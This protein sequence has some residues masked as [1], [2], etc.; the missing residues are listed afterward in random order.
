MNPTS[1]AYPMTDP[2]GPEDQQDGGD[3]SRSRR[4][5]T[6][7]TEGERELSQDAQ[8][9]M[10][11]LPGPSESRAPG[12]THSR[13]SGTADSPIPVDDNF[14]G[15]RDLGG[16]RRLLF[17]SPRKD[18]V[19]KVLGELAVNIVQTAPD[20]QQPKPATADKENV[21]QVPARATTPSPPD[22]DD[23]DQELFG[24]PPA[25][26]STPPPKSANAGPFKTPTRPTPSHR[27]ITRSI[28]RSIR[29]VKSGAKSPSQALLQLQRTPSKTPRSV[30]GGGALNFSLGLSFSASKRRTP[31]P[32][33][34]HAHF[35]L[36]A[37][38]GHFDSPFT[39]T[40][41]QL[42]SEANEFTSGSPSHGL[43]DMDLSSLPNL[44]SDDVMQQLADAA[45]CQQLDFGNFLPG[46]MGLP[47]SPP[48]LRAGRHENNHSFSGMDEGAIAEMWAKL[49]AATAADGTADKA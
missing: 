14:D 48:M 29:S 9:T 26:P 7:F 45:N 30:S 11:S 12:S 27:P 8:P 3:A 40:I 41:N 5:S 31:R 24:T 34:V 21:N 36:E 32:N 17:P 47:S 4:Q 44:N 33:P 28:S 38:N 6:Q 49:S 35:A 20:F 39:A 19:P 25:R 13:G 22:D 46:D 42:L 18:G 15:P 43:A 1:D 16:T 23:L 10:L 2:F 37:A